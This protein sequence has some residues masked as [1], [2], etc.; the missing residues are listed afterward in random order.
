M[1]A[2]ISEFPYV[3]ADG[4]DRPVLQDQRN[5]DWHILDTVFEAQ[6]V[7]FNEAIVGMWARIKAEQLSWSEEV[8]LYWTE[9]W[10]L[11]PTS[12]EL[13]WHLSF[14]VAEILRMNGSL[15]WSF[16]ENCGTQSDS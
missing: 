16:L 11:M 14:G 9:A 7:S 4:Q 10:I 1:P 13:S 15:S 5:I 6:V 2:F 3:R 12:F 8:C